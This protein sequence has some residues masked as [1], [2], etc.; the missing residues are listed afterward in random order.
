[1]TN[2]PKKQTDPKAHPKGRAREHVEHSHDTKKVIAKAP[3]F[4]K[5]FSHSAMGNR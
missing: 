4:P 3:A 1:M 2:D 5:R